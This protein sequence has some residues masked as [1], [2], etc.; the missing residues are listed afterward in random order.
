M[1]KSHVFSIIQ[2]CD[3]LYLQKLTFFKYFQII[4]NA[5]II[6]FAYFSHNF[7]TL[8]NVNF[9]GSKRTFPAIFLERSFFYIILILFVNSDFPLKPPKPL[10][11]RHFPPYPTPFLLCLGFV[12]YLGNLHPVY[13]IYERLLIGSA[14]SHL[15]RVPDSRDTMSYFPQ[16]AAAYLTA[17]QAV[18]SLSR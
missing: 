8:I 7:I 13:N 4:I 2:I 16:L 12:K 17:Y 9:N 11:Y 6:D 18:L 14:I 10:I 5:S 1:G 15:H 3:L